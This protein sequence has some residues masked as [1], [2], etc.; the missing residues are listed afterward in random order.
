MVLNSDSTKGLSLG[1]RGLANNWGMSRHFVG[2]CV[3]IASL[4]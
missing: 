3:G 4:Q 2:N 1:V